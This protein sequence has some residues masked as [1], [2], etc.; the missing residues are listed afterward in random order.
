M[1]I[2]YFGDGPWAVEA[3]SKILQDQRLQVQFI[4]VRYKS[5][6]PS[7]RQM[8]AECQLPVYAFKNINDAQTHE[9]LS[10]HHCDLFVSMSFDQIFKKNLFQLPPLG[11]INCHAGELPRYRGRNVINWALING[12]KHIGITVHAIDEG[13]DT[14]PIIEQV[15]VSLELED[16]YASTLQKCYTACADVL[17][18]ALQ[19]IQSDPAAARGRPQQGVGFYCVKRSAA[20]EVLDW[21]WPSARVHNFVRG[22]SPPAP[23]AST[24]YNDKT[25]RIWK[26]CPVESAPE[27]IGVPGSIVG[28]Q[29]GSFLV[30]TGDSYIEILEWSFDGANEI[31]RMGGRFT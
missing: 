6:D 11:T 2:G 8:A 16:D 22:I 7:L 19:K 26:A 25:M 31:L 21:N 9:V 20:D 23:G 12:E 15:K 28:L 1:K 13:I 17:H 14:G 3:L 4:V 29:A 18:S 5:T 10:A 30:K 27:Y 24:K